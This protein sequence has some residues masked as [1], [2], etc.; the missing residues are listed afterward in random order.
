MT[1]QY[2]FYFDATACTGCKA[3]QIA[4]QDKN[5][6]TENE[7]WRRVVHY[8]GGGWTVQEGFQVP[9]NIFGYAVS[10][11]CNH[12]EKPICADVCPTKAITKRADAIVLVD[13]DKCIGCRY[14]EWAC[15]YGAPRFDEEAGVMQK[16]TFCEDLLAKGENPACVDACVMRVLDYGPLVELRAKYGNVR[17]VEPLP[18]GTY[19]YPAL[20]ITPHKHAQMSGTGTGSLET[21]EEA[22]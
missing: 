7:V 18:E 5:H 8:S 12:C 14:C 20:V 9:N 3:C 4:C 6:L 17:A 10:V 11:A 15:P 19:T 2:A 16:C 13:A 21:L 1:S 22:L